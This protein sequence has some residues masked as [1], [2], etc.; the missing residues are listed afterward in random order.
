[1]MLVMVFFVEQKTA[2]EMRISDLSSDVCSSDR[3][4][5]C[6][7]QYRRSAELWCS[8]HRI[9]A[10]KKARSEERRVGKEC[11]STCRSRWS[12]D[13][14]KKTTYTTSINIMAMQHDYANFHHKQ[15]SHSL[16]K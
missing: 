14:Y 11:V 15:H 6:H 2:F 3:G 16:K 7:A 8:D 5:A 13:H 10:R 1:M 4:K 12:A 9:E